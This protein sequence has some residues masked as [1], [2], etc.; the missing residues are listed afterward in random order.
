MTH[1]KKDLGTAEAL[2]QPFTGSIER[3]APYFNKSEPRIIKL[4]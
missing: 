1:K 4:R 2:K 3:S